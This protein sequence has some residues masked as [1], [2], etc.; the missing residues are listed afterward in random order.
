MADYEKVNQVGG[1]WLVFNMFL[2][3]KSANTD[4]PPI[5]FCN[6]PLIGSKYAFAATT[7]Y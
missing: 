2:A 3:V 5:G 6:E 7:I 1:V 4:R